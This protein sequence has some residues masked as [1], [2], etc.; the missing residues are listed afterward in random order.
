MIP[1]FRRRRRRLQ[2]ITG[3]MTA[4]YVLLWFGLLICRNWTR[5]ALGFDIMT[6]VDSYPT[7]VQM[8]MILAVFLPTIPGTFVSWWVRREKQAFRQGKL[9]C[10]NCLYD[11]RGTTGNTCGECG[12]PFTIAGIEDYFQHLSNTGMRRQGMIGASTPGARCRTPLISRRRRQITIFVFA[13]IGSYVLFYVGIWRCPGWTKQVL[14]VDLFTLTDPNSLLRYVVPGMP[15]IT[16][17]GR[18]LAIYC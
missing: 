6:L 18:Q 11:L 7:G 10:L 14:G 8:G 17:R 4:S 3:A 16:R 2:I 15:M 1:V 13:A 9:P 5:H 12:A